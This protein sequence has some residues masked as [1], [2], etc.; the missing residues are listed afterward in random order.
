MAAAPVRLLLLDEARDPDGAPRAALRVPPM[1][2][3]YGTRPTT[4]LYPSLDAA[5]AAKR[6]LEGAA[7]A[8]GA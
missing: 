1:P 3:R 2:G 7:D 6:D 4:I 8:R 5:L